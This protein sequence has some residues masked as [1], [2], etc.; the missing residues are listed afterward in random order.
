[1][2]DK[3]TSLG[4][5]IAVISILVI[6]GAALAALLLVYNLRTKSAGTPATIFACVNLFVLLAMIPLGK[7]VAAASSFASSVQIWFATILYSTAQFTTL[8]LAADVWRNVAYTLCQL[9]ILALW[10]GI[11][12]AAIAMGK[13]NH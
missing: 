11:V 9:V 6:C 10:F 8:F 2:Q 7:R 5:V 13:R 4:A 12:G 3:R 1:M